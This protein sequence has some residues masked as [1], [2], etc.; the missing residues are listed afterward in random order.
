MPGQIIDLTTDDPVPEVPAPAPKA[1][2]V[3]SC[4]DSDTES[5]DK[6][7]VAFKKAPR[8]TPVKMQTFLAGVNKSRVEA[9]TESDSSLDETEAQPLNATGILNLVDNTEVDNTEADKIEVDK[10][11]VDKTEV[12]NTKVDQAP[13]R[14]R[15]RPIKKNRIT[16]KP[17]S[18]KS[19]RFH[20]AHER[21]IQ[22]FNAELVKDASRDNAAG[23]RAYP[24]P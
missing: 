13:K 8:K 12:D 2:H 23:G 15:K 11:E 1:I 14:K 6:E 20:A 5:D 7:E 21:Y 24:R 22:K 4:S 9:D 3:R 18:S 16:A 17:M 10:T 19:E